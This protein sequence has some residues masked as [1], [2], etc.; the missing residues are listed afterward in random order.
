MY[1]SGSLLNKYNIPLGS[2]G[3]GSVRF[4]RSLTR[5]HHQTP[6]PAFVMIFLEIEIFIMFVWYKFDRFTIKI[7]NFFK[8]T[9]KMSIIESKNFVSGKKGWEGGAIRARLARPQW[10]KNKINMPSLFE[11]YTKK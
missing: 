6:F 1:Y 11:K 4:V 9:P 8:K 10:A 2:V 3:F 7:A 5:T